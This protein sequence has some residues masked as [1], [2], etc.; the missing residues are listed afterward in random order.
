MNHLQYLQTY[1]SKS[2]INNAGCS[3]RLFLSAIY[4]EGN[5][6]ELTKKYLQENR[7]RETDIQ[8]FLASVKNRPPTS[9]RVIISHIKILMLEILSRIQC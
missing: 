8:S 6:E 7:D 9:I 1:S 5:I 2:T 4:G 3:I